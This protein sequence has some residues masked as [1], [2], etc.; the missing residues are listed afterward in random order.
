MQATKANKEAVKGLCEDATNL[1]DDIEGVAKTV[2]RRFENIP[3]N[4]PDRVVVE[5]ALHSVKTL[6]LNIR[7]DGLRRC[8]GLIPS[9]CYRDRV[10]S[11]YRELD[12]VLSEAGILANKPRVTRF[13]RTKQDADAIT[14]MREKINNARHNFQV[15]TFCS[16]YTSFD[17]PA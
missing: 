9:G 5:N 14:R 11:I 1:C 3:R 6:D 15:C 13:L 2:R 16:G 12:E 7:I 10:L 8:I 4:S 17:I